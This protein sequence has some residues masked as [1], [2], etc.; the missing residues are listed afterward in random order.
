ML[1]GYVKAMTMY[2]ALITN[3]TLMTDNVTKCNIQLLFNCVDM[4]FHFAKNASLLP[5]EFVFET[6]LE[7]MVVRSMP[8]PFMYALTCVPVH[9][10]DDCVDYVSFILT[11]STVEIIP[12]QAGSVIID[13]HDHKMFFKMHFH[14]QIG[15]LIVAGFLLV[16]LTMILT[17]V[18]KK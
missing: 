9:R 15:E 11:N 10:C 3:V 16:F 2:T 7:V 14:K 18:L 5:L 13:E 8:C 6:N 17:C 4:S 12:K 1:T